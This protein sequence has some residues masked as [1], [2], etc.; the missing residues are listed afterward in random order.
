MNNISKTKIIDITK[1]PIR[2][3]FNYISFV[4]LNKIH[5][6]PDK[7][8]EINNDINRERPSLETGQK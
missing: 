8:E 4:W 7:I 2:T 1:T 3:E 6:N 5:K